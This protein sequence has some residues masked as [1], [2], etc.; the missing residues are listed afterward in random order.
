MPLFFSTFN[1][2]LEVS[3]W[4]SDS[5]LMG[6]KGNGGSHVYRKNTVVCLQ[7][8]KYKQSHIALIVHIVISSMLEYFP[9][10]LCII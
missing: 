5:D 9:I 1:L 6:G 2:D 10:F 3:D 4:L 8:G 7:H